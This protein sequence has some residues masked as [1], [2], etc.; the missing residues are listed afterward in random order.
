MFF[1]Y[2]NGLNMKTALLHKHIK[3]HS[4]FSWPSNTHFTILM[5]FFG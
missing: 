4:S 2:Y 3:F 1:A 5:F